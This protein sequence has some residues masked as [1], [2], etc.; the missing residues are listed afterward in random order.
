MSQALPVSGF[1]CPMDVGYFADPDDCSAYFICDEDVATRTLCSKGKAIVLV[2]TFLF[3]NNDGMTKHSLWWHAVDGSRLQYD[4][5]GSQCDWHY[6][7]DCE[8]RP[9]HIEDP[10]QEPETTQRPGEFTCPDR[11]GY[12]ADAHDCR[13]FYICED[14]VVVSHSTCG[15]SKAT[16]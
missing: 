14:S 4:P 8:S 11:Y 16:F 15:Q 5:I 9:E 7:V 13:N 6:L 2:W 10:D 12:Y 3:S 1:V